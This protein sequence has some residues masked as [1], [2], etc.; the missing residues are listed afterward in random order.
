VTYD[1]SHAQ[2]YINGIANGKGVDYTAI[3]L[4]SSH[5]TDSWTIGSSPD[6]TYGLN[7]EIYA[8][9]VYDRTLGSS[10]NIRFI[11]K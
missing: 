5:N 10:R 7:G 4:S 8:F 6:T 3:T 2:L 9:Y 11:C 1:G